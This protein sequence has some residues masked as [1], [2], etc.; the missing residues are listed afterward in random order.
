MLPL[1]LPG[2][3]WDVIA[4]LGPVGIGLKKKKIVKPGGRLQRARVWLQ[5]RF[6]IARAALA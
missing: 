1:A 4:C 6:K 2:R 3:P 5:E